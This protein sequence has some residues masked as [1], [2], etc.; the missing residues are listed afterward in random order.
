LPLFLADELEQQGMRKAWGRVVMLSRLLKASV[1]AATAT[2]TALVIALFSVGN[3]VT[4]FADVTA[5]LVDKPGLQ[6]GTDQSD[7]PPVLTGLAADCKE[8]TDL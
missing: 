5:S 1:L 4:L 7:L 3:P 6:P 2:A 8:C